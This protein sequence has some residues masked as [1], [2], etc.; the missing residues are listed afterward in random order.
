MTR[1]THAH[2]GDLVVFHIGMTVRRWWRVDQWAP[3][4]AAMPR[5]L[6]E[7]YR[8]QAAAQRG[9]EEWLGFLGATQLAGAQ[10]PWII[11]YWRSV[12]DLHRYAASSAAAHLPAWR[13]F[14]RRARTSPGS[15]GI[16]HETY[17]VPAGGIES[18]Y[19]G[20]K[21]PL[22]LGAVGGTVDVGRRGDRA[23]ARLGSRVA[24]AR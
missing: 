3:V 23:R 21:R 18:I 20:L 13:A 11:Q 19:S 24:D 9:E 7:L 1:L 10:G 16:W 15:V 4:A 12:E 17:V 2:D 14:N 22:G 6:A 8:N 5:M